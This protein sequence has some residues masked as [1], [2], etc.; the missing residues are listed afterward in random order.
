MITSTKIFGEPKLE[1]LIPYDKVKLDV[2]SMKSQIENEYHQDSLRLE[3]KEVHY[4]YIIHVYSNLTETYI[5]LGFKIFISV[6]SCTSQ[7]MDSEMYCL[8]WNEFEE[9][10]RNFF[11]LFRSEGKLFDVTLASD[12]GHQI[13]A[14]KIILSAGSDF[15]SRIFSECNQRNM[16]VYLKGIS[17]TDLENVTNFLYNGETLVSHQESNAF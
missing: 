3:Y 12:D 11:N 16:L 17:R 15:F 6:D 13:Q 5:C 2:K 14:H 1:N 10:I 9:N 7:A 8:K 4:F